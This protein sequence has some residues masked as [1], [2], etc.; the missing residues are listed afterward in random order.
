[1]K[2]NKLFSLMKQHKS[3]QIRHGQAA[4]WVGD[5][6]SLYPVYN[7]PPLSESAIQTLLGVSDDA[8]D[9]FAF[10]DYPTMKF[11][12]DDTFRDMYQLERMK[13]TLNWSGKSLI[14]LIGGGKIFFIQE[15]Y[16]RPFDDDSLLSFWFRDDPVQIGGII[17]INEGMCLGGLVMPIIVKD[18]VFIETLY[19]VYALTK[20]QAGEEA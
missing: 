18:R 17:G 20:R 1:M 13:I 14:P 7:L 6:S 11:S 10:D 16:L 2:L 5:S 8:W 4:Q 3:V 19:R 9:K 12:E 15:K